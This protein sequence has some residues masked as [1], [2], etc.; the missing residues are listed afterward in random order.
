MSKTNKVKE[1]F[2]KNYE[3]ITWG[4]IGA[5]AVISGALVGR[6]VYMEGLKKGMEV[7][8]A[9][10]VH[11]L[12]STFKDLDIKEKVDKYMLEYGINK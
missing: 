3:L 5:A 12:D 8:S 2:E 11:W 7:G 6:K 10:T 1:F 9:F 4:A